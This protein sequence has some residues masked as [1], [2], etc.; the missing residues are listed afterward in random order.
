VVRRTIEDDPLYAALFREPVEAG[1]IAARVRRI[2]WVLRRLRPGD[3]TE[4]M[5]RFQLAGAFRA[6]YLATGD[7]ADL[8]ATVRAIRAAVAAC[9]DGHP[10]RHLV[11]GNAGAALQARFEAG[12]RRADLDEAVANGRAAVSTAPP[13]PPGALADSQVQLALSL[14]SR[15]RETGDRA[16]LDEAAVLARAA[17]TGCTVVDPATASRLINACTVVAELAD[18][19]DDTAYCDEALAMA[20]RVVAAHRAGT[21]DLPMAEVTLG[22]AMLVRARLTDDPA[23]RDEAIA[24][25]RAGRAALPADAP[26]RFA[27][28]RLLAKALNARAATDDRRESIAL[29]QEIARRARQPATRRD[30]VADAVVHLGGMYSQTGDLAWTDRAIAT[31][32]QALAHARP[33]SAHAHRMNLAIM[34]AGRYDVTGRDEDL[35]EAVDLA[36]GAVGGTPV[37]A[38]DLNYAFVLQ[39]MFRRTGEVGPL[40]LAIAH[41]RS[42]AAGAADTG[43]VATLAWNAVNINLRLRFMHAGELRDIDEAVEAGRRAVRTAPARSALR[44]R[45]INSCSSTLL[46]R[47]EATGDPADL[48]EAIGHAREA[49]LAGADE[50]AFRPRYLTGLSTALVLRARHLTDLDEAAVAADEAVRILPAEDRYLRQVAYTAVGR[51]AAHRF[52]HSHDVA[53]LDR[54]ADAYRQALAEPVGSGPYTAGLLHLAAR[55]LHD[56]GLVAGQPDDLR[57]AVRLWTELAE[58][59]DAPANYRFVAA[60]QMARMHAATAA[61][62]PA[63]ARYATAIALLPLLVWPGLSRRSQES[64]LSGTDGVAGEAASCAVAAGQPDQAV[65]LVDHGRGLLWAQLLETRSDVSGLE[66]AAPE[67]AG[68]LRAVAEARQAHHRAEEFMPRPSLG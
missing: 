22:Q 33:A 48:D 9:P 24:L 45:S 26:D 61:W 42:A 41:A 34:L 55:V 62:A 3:E 32:R 29:N 46:S 50:P 64:R 60:A 37:P 16:D 25:L 49:V 58:L 68:R 66:R 8:N 18:L 21:V 19:D 13:A 30:A 36:A 7:P 59:P 14:W 65:T 67:L 54:A 4:W 5:L 43:D 57:A 31:A 12:G 28:M 17:T 1:E 52:H 39:M 51:A 15:Y 53:D 11:L 38:F 44:G 23:T 47:F 56:R 2:R 40:D 6:R 27:V 20:G 63:T 10:D 35:D